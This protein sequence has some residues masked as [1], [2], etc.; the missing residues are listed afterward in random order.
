MYVKDGAF[1][2]RYDWC[3]VNVIIDDVNDHTPYFLYSEFF[4]TVPENNDDSSAPIF[5]VVALDDDEGQNANLS[6]SIISKYLLAFYLRHCRLTAT[7]RHQFHSCLA[8]VI[9]VL[10]MI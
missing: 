3:T 2:A 10:F 7:N 1:P 5:Q 9:L 6:Y 4:Q 8:S